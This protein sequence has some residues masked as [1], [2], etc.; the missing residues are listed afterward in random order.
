[1]SY[2]AAF[3]A[4]VLA[5]LSLAVGTGPAAIEAGEVAVAFVV[6]A[7]VLWATDHPRPPTG[8]RTA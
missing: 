4:G 5:L 7:L 3:V 2:L 6:L 1:M 8:T